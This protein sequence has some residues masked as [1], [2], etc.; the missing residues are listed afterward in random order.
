MEKL[1][2]VILII[3]YCSYCYEGL[4]TTAD[5]IPRF[6]TLEFPSYEENQVLHCPHFSNNYK[7]Q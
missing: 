7:A 3:V 2:T 4:F 5:Y 6:W 1:F